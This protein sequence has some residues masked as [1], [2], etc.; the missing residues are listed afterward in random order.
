MALICFHRARRRSS[1]RWRRR[2][3]ASSGTVDP[4][5]GASAIES[6]IY[7]CETIKID[8]LKLYPP[9]PDVRGWVLD[10]EK[11]T[12]SAVR[13]AASARRQECVRSQGSARAIPRRVLPY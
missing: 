3:S 13:G 12:I 8:G 1:A 2:A 10:D 7:Q 4:P 11:N 6:L 9:G 5:D